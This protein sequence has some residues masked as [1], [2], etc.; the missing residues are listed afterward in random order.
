MESRG[1]L[2]ANVGLTW[3]SSTIVNYYYGAPAI[4]QG[5]SALDPFLKLGYTVPLAGQW[6]FSAFAQYERLGRAIADSPIV[7]EHYVATAFV[8]AIYAF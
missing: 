8:G 4:Y 7:E 5:G 1:A 3:K 6:R 2:T